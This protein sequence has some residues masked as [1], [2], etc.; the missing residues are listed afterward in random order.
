MGFFDWVFGGR[1]LATGDEGL[2]RA[3]DRVLH[4][5]DPR[6]KL[7][8][9]ARTRLA[10][11][12]QEAL[13]FA[14][15]TIARMPESVALTPENWARDPLLRATFARP[16]D[17]EATLAASQEVHDFIETEAGLGDETFFG[18]LAATRVE[19]KVFGA[20]LDGGIL[21]HDVL[22]K[23]VSFSDFRIAA[24]ARAETATRRALEDFVL[25]QLALAA[26]GEIAEQRKQA[27]HLE[28]YRQL[29]LAR[30][31]LMEQ[32]GAGLDAL[33]A[34]EESERPD[35]V[36]LRRELALNAEQLAAIRASG[37]GL[38]GMLERLIEALHNAEAIIQPQRLA[39]NL[40]AMNIVVPRQAATSAPVELLEF[41][42]INPEHPRRVAFLVSFPRTI[43]HERHV[44]LE[45]LR[46]MI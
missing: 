40:D 33:F 9:D 19:R 7:L 10:P 12:V 2:M 1:D 21:R 42:T 6:L 29:L 5:I 44:D 22:Q 4:G 37:R 45:A 14:R 23:T 26:M 15:E 13:D 20:A 34:R 25:E 28:S 11:A 30:L 31:R 18:V 8:R 16:G 39:L 3:V 38:E 36:R 32:S 43:V 24:L 41:S 46:R 17:I 27:E 35:L